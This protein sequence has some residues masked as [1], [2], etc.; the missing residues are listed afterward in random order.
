MARA[1]SRGILMVC[2]AVVILVGLIEITDRI[3]FR[4]HAIISRIVREFEDRLDT[5]EVLVL[6]PSDMGAA[7]IPSELGAPGYNLAFPGETT[8]ETYFKLRHYIDRLPQLRMVLLP[9]T[10]GTFSAARE[11]RISTFSLKE[12]VPVRD[13]PDLRRLY[14]FGIIG[15]RLLAECHM[16]DPKARRGFADNVVR[17]ARGLAISRVEL[18]DGFRE[19]RGSNVRRKRLGRLMARLYAAGAPLDEKAL[20]YFRKTLMLCADRKIKVVTV[21]SPFTDLYIERVEKYVSGETLYRDVVEH[22]RYSPLIEKHM[23]YT[24]IF[25][26]RRELFRDLNHLNIEGARVF[27][28]RLAADLEP[29]LNPGGIAGALGEERDSGK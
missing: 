25:A 7:I 19:R 17:Y 9:L 22:P 24:R 15:R 1:V 23:D 28:R 27:S 2:V 20:F 12:Y 11:G 5:V 21:G 26:S 8:M 13:L 14:G 6:G 4:P 10:Y 29:L 16:L 18:R 3:A